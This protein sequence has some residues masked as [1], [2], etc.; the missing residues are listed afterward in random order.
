MTVDNA[1]LTPMG[2]LFFPNMEVALQTLSSS[3]SVLLM[4]VLLSFL[5]FLFF[6]EHI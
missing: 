6:L 3:Y 1:Q 4:N 2:C 5:F